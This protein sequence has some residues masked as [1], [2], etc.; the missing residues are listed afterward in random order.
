MDPLGCY[1]LQVTENPSLKWL[2]QQSHRTG[3]SQVGRFW[4]QFYQFPRRCRRNQVSFVLPLKA[5]SFSDPM[6]PAGSNWDSML[7]CWC[8]KSLRHLE[9]LNPFP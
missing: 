1:W 2:N 7:F 8:S 4:V 9:K 3:S 5:A 6:R